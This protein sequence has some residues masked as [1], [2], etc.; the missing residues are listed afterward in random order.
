[1]RSSSRRSN[2][3]CYDFGAGEGFANTIVEDATTDGS[4]FVV[5]EG[6]FFIRGAFVTVPSQLLILD[7]YGTTPSY[8][9]GLTIREQ[10]I[11]SDTDPLL[12]DNASGFNNFA[13][14]GAEDLASPQLSQ[15]FRWL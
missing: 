12:T 11:S 9:V 7:Q 8:R 6:V 15:R 10:L 5:S 1:M 4:A 3:I 13:A 14:P 2:H